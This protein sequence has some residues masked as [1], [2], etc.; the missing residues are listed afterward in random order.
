[1]QIAE[2]NPDHC[3]TGRAGSECSFHI[4]THESNVDF[5]SVDFPQAQRLTVHILAAVVEHEAQM[6]SARTRAGSE[7]RKAARY[8]SW[9]ATA[10]I[11]LQS[12]NPGQRQALWRDSA[13][14]RNAIPICCRSSG[15]LNPKV[16]H[17]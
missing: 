10:A 16:P 15:K 6:I 4:R 11:S 5:I 1:M 9:V 13:R 8:G 2:G 14:Q 7:G 3:Q 17:P 12:P